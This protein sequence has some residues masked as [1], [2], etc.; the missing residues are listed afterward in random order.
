MMSWLHCNRCGGLINTDD[1]PGAFVDTGVGI[2]TGEWICE[3]CREDL[4]DEKPNPEA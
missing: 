4:E 3:R 1:D 2:Y